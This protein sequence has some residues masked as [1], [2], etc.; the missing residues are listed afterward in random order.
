MNE[1]M[2]S[3]GKSPF[4]RLGGAPVLMN[5]LRG[6]YADV[7]QDEVI[8]PI[9]DAHIQ[10]WP[11]HLDRIGSF[12]ARQLGAFSNYSGGFGAAHLP[13][14]LKEIHFQ[15]WL[16]LWERHCR[17]ELD[18]ESAEFLIVR[19]HEIAQQLRRMM[20]GQMGPRIGGN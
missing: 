19:A 17:R 10:D 12:W 6:F 3:A 14:Q 9:F 11:T 1:P 18:P 20:A 13:L 8:G 5:L 4:E 16:G 7:R 2:G 15:R